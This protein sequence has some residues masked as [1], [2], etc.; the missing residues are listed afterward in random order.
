M[1]LVDGLDAAAKSLQ[2]F[3]E[4]M[5]AVSAQTIRIAIETTQEDRTSADAIKRGQT[6]ETLAAIRKALGL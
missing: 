3:A 4:L 6:P 2:A 1:A 5:D